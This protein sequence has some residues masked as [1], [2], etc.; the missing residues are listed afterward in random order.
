MRNAIGTLYVLVIEKVNKYLDASWI[1]G[2]I[3]YFI[4]HTQRVRAFNS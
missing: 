3:E 2:R 4:R 1:G